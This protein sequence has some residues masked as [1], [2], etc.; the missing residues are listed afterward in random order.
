MTDI[1]IMT[2][3]SA[4]HPYILSAAEIPV[5]YHKA[6]FRGQPLPSDWK[7]LPFSIE[8]KS[9]RLADALAFEPSFPLFSSRATELLKSVCSDC[10]EFRLFAEIKGKPYFLINV[11]TAADVLDEDRSEVTRTDSGEIMNIQRYAF[12]PVDRASLPPIFKLPGRFDSHILVTRSIP[13]LVL[14]HRLSGFEFRDPAHDP[15]Q[16]LFFG[17][18]VNVFPGLVP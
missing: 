1:Y 2:A 7:P 15:V 5:A 8:R 10:A 4:G 16:D 14:L 12:K 3:A 17:R 6:T 9:A 11:L 13:E 18:S